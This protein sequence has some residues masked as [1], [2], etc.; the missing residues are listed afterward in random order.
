ML[1][2]FS[3]NLSLTLSCDM[4]GNMVQKTDVTTLYGYIH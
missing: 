3:T 4:R 1:P 2:D